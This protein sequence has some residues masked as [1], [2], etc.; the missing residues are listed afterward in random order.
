MSSTSGR[1]AYTLSKDLVT[2][3]AV[4]M[5]RNLHILSLKTLDFGVRLGV[6]FTSFPRLE[7]LYHLKLEFDT[8]LTDSFFEDIGKCSALKSLTLIEDDINGQH[9]SEQGPR[10]LANLQKLT[11]LHLNGVW[12]VKD[13]TVVDDQLAQATLLSHFRHQEDMA[14][15]LDVSYTLNLLTTP[16][17]ITFKVKRTI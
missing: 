17:S 7:Q 5:V 4:N 11:E 8:F 16:A 12:H 6:P 14:H 13:N 3:L 10:Y 1:T 9:Y 15:R 2:A